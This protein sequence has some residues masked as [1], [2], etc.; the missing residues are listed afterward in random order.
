M[1]TVEFP[2][3][4]G[5]SRPGVPAEISADVSQYLRG[6]LT[7]VALRRIVAGGCSLESPLR[8]AQG[9]IQ[10][11]R[12]ATGAG[13]VITLIVRVA[14]CRPPIFGPRTSWMVECAFAHAEV[15]AVRE[16]IAALIEDVMSDRRVA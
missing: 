6:T 13:R 3:T 8:L 9:S 5:A 11:L 4:S 14:S 2:R 15:P 12:C 10:Q 7:P 16:Q 1:E